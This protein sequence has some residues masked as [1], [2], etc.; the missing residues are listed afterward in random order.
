M[1]V[2]A[3]DHLAGSGGQGP[4]GALLGAGLGPAGYVFAIWSVIYLL[5]LVR[6]VVW[7]GP[8]ARGFALAVASALL[9]VLALTFINLNLASK[10]EALREL[11]NQMDEAGTKSLTLVL[12]TGISIGVV[13]SM[14]S[15]GTLARFGAEAVLPSMLA[16]S[17][18]K[19][20]GPVITSLVLAGR[21]DQA[22]VVLLTATFFLVRDEPETKTVTAHFSRA[23]S[24]GAPAERGAPR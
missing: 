3:H 6:A 19:E 14:Q 17:V 24:V 22:A 10:N 1:S 18:F 9:L 7:L 12:V 21:Q 13:L 4:V 2:T 8:E 5:L 20:I 23:V 15:R 16:L 11:F